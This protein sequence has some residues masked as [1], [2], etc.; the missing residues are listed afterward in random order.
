MDL[1]KRLIPKGSLEVT[2]EDPLGSVLP[3]DSST[4]PKF[5]K[6]VWL[7]RRSRYG[8]RQKTQREAGDDHRI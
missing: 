1:S 7:C 3:Q 2:A 4:E 6:G 8:A 5:E